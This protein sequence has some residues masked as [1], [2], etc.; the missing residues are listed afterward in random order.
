MNSKELFDS[1][2]DTANPDEMEID[3]KS[4]VIPHF[5]SSTTFFRQYSR[6]DDFSSSIIDV[7]LCSVNG[8]QLTLDSDHLPVFGEF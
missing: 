8:P 1:H 6:I 3:D 5:P 4:A 2:G 7:F